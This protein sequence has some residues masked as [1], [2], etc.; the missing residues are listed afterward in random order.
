MKKI[1]NNLPQQAQLPLIGI[2]DDREY[3]PFVHSSFSHAGICSDIERINLENRYLPLFSTDD[4]FNRKVVSFQANKGELVHSWLK[5]REGFSSILVETLLNDFGLQAGDT[6]LDPF[7]GSATTL[8]V[9]KTRGIN[10]VGIDILPNCHLAWQAKSL[11]SVYDIEELKGIYKLV[12]ETEIGQSARKYPHITITESAFDMKVENDLM[13]YTDWFENLSISEN[14]KIL[15]KLILTSILEDISFTRKDGQYLRWDYRSA[16]L[17]ERN[18]IRK[19]QEKPEIGGIDK[20]V[21]IGVKDAVINSLKDVISDIEILQSKYATNSSHQELIPGSVLQILPTLPENS[22]SS[23]IT[24][25]PYANRYDYTRTYALELVYLG[26]G[27]EIAQ[28]RQ[29]LLSCTVESKSKV[30]LLKDYYEQLGLLD[31]YNQ[32]MS[33]IRNNAA[34]N[35]VNVSLKIRW[36]RGD[37]NNKGVLPMINQYFSELTFVFAEIFRTCI[38]GSYI[39]FVN[40][41]VRYGGEIIPVD[42]ITTHLAEQLGFEPVRIIVLEQKKGNSSQQMEKFGREEMR[43]CITIW[44]KPQA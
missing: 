44:R 14:A 26:M 39:A 18:A 11:C 19:G 24:S 22:F 33:I 40:D 27:P 36:D 29:K 21:L 23:V 20:G 7:A 12:V 28:L 13:W 25:P 30:A 35:E 3:F 15:C 5:Y 17:Q 1:N 34:L 8:L 9:A 41:D 16:K 10:A 4:R 43:K 37:M 32:I 2:N 38:P 31:R 6:I 42:T